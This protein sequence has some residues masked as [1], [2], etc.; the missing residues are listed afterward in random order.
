MTRRR[1]IDQYDENRF[2]RRPFTV[3]EQA[4]PEDRALCTSGKAEGPK[5]VCEACGA[6]VA[7]RK[8]GTLRGH[9]VGT[10]LKSSVSCIGAQPRT[11]D[12][13]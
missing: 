7:L 13:R 1:H 9:R 11:G 8:D 3:A 10:T 4:G 12:E 2:G 5:G 6:V